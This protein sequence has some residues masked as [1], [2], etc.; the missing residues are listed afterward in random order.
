[1]FGETIRIR[2]SPV[3]INDANK[4]VLIGLNLILYL[5]RHPEDGTAVK[6]YLD[7]KG[8]TMERMRYY[9]GSYPSWIKKAIRQLETIEKSEEEK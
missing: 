7:S 2:K 8:L 1:M 6:A 9:I 5:V 4:E 3:P